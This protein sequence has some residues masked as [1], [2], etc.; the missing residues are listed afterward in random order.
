MSLGIDED[1][2]GEGSRVITC[3]VSCGTLWAVSRLGRLP[4][5]MDSFLVF[6]HLVEMT[7]GRILSVVLVPEEKCQ[8]GCKGNP[9]HEM[10]H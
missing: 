2:M 1:K 10:Q 7:E 4:T 5:L 3:G 8:V 9:G 6:L